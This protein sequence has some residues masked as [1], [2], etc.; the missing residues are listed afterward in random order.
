MAYNHEFPYTDMGRANTDWEINTIKDLV[1]KI[2]EFI[3]ANRIKIANPIQWDI[4]KQYEQNTLVIDGTT[5]DAYLSTQPV[6]AGFDLTHTE[7]WMKVFTLGNQLAVVE[8][9]IAYSEG[10]STRATKDFAVGDLVWV[11]DFLYEV[12]RPIETGE[13]FDVDYNTQLVTV[14]ELLARE[15]DARATADAEIRERLAITTFDYVVARDGSGDFTSLATAVS[16]VP[17]GSRILVKAGVYEDEVVQCVGKELTII[18]QNPY[19]TIVRNSADDYYNPPLN[20]GKGFVSGITFASTG[21]TGA[22]HSYA[23]HID[24]DDLFG[25]S[26]IF[27]DCRF[28]SASTSA[29]GIGTRKNC[30]LVFENCEFVSTSGTTDAFFVHPT[31]DAN[32]YSLAQYLYLIN[33]QFKSSAAIVMHIGKYG[34]SAN[35]VMVTCIGCTLQGGSSA[36]RH[37]LIWQSGTGDGRIY[38][39]RGA[40]NNYSLLNAETWVPGQTINTGRYL[41]QVVRTITVDGTVTGGV[42]GQFSLPADCQM[43]LD[44]TGAF[45]S[46]LS[47]ISFPIGTQIGGTTD[48][49]NCYYNNTSK[50]MYVASQETCYYVLNITYLSSSDDYF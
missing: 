27:H 48:Y 30:S 2:K 9:A 49:Y 29:V 16:T 32:N 7:Y 44:V 35:G 24:N 40:G 12:I 43:V 36:N 41:D 10:N 28:Q 14:E 21:T 26:L 13:L 45:T 38:F 1:K 17:T 4:T 31:T 11:N 37:L 8:A 42:Q 50:V 15:S 25:N 39:V 33:C 20:I 19:K 18:G 47:G 34:T 23:A 46:Q 22:T 5:G 6:P 3:A